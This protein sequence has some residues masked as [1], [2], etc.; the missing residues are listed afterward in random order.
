MK[1]KNRFAAIAALALAFTATGLSSNAM[2]DTTTVD[3]THMRQFWTQYGVPSAT[4]TRLVAQVVSGKLTDAESED[5][6]PISETTATVE[7]ARQTVKRFADGS[8]SVSEA[9]LPALVEVGA[10]SVTPFGV[11]N[12]T[13]TTYSGLAQY[14]N[15]NITA[16]TALTTLGFIA[17]FDLVS[18]A[19]ND[20]IVDQGNSGF[21]TCG[22]GT[23]SKPRFSDWTQ[24][25]TS[26]SSAR[27]RWVATYTAPGVSNTMYVTLTVGGNSYH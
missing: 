14:R 5:A 7:G 1:N 22:P 8:V 16:S 10:Q 27:L 20:Y 24:R 23:C 9:E 13:L 19:Y 26:S 11:A 4:Q 17:N 21:E 6:H 12:C 2:A 3:T 18:G 25:E 15:C